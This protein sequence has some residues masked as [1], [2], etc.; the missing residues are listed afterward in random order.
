MCDLLAHRTEQQSPKTAEPPGAH[1]QK[2]GSG[3]P[4][5][6][7]SRGQ[8]ADDMQLDLDL[9]AVAGSAPDRLGQVLPSPGFAEVRVEGLLTRGAELVEQAPR[10]DGVEPSPP[11][12]RF[13]HGEAQRTLPAR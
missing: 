9:W 2:V 4:F 10:E 7:R 8:V 6:Q 3:G 13:I 5:E 1:D 11:D 12:P